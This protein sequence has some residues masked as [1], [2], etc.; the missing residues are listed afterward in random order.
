MTADRSLIAYPALVLGGIC[1]LLHAFANQHY[2]FFRDELYFIVCGRHPDWGY[3]D[4]PPLVPLIAAFADWAAPGSLTALRALPALLQTLL[5]AA[6]VGLT[7]Y[8][9]AGI[10]ARWLAGLCVLLAPVH[11]LF[12]TLLFTE[13]FMPLAWLCCA[14]LLIRMLRTGDARGWVAFG[15]VVGLALWSK[16]MILFDVAALAIA[17]PFSPLR[18][19]LVT[20]WPYVGAVIALAIIAPNIVWQSRHGWPF[21][22]LGAAAA[23]GRGLTL[24]PQAYL[25]SQIT[26]FGPGAAVWIAGLAAVA[27]APAWRLYRLFALQWVVLVAIEVALHGKDY[28]PSSLYPPLF[29]F[30]AAAIDTAVRAAWARGAFAA[31]VLA[32]G[33]VVMPLAL[34]ILPVDKLIA[35]EDALGYRPAPSEQRAGAEMP[36]YFGDMFGWREMAKAVSDAYWALPE[37]ERAKAV[38]KARNYGEAAAIDVF[39]DHLPPAISGHNNY[40]LWGPGGHDGSVIIATGDDTKDAES[41][42]TSVEIVGR[43]GNAHAMPDETGLILFVCRGLKIPLIDLWPRFKNYS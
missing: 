41:V 37:D 20:P 9:G 26:L 25:L 6:T 2:G 17:L 35:Y 23:T 28:Y 10:Y 22:E 1:L 32:G 12:G 3:V 30:G 38:F 7:R 33:L 40:Y 4:Q 19:T 31:L 36:Q 42:C 8:L 16:Y 13:L 24:S 18:R 39:G 5:I 15:I 34:P 43:I 14:F 21:L 27:F 11:L 29:A